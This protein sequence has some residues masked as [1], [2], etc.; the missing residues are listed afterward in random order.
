MGAGMSK[1]S[2]IASIALQCITN[3]YMIIGKILTIPV[4]IAGKVVVSAIDNKNFGK[5]KTEEA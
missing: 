2:S 4:Q 5:A 1:D 3:A